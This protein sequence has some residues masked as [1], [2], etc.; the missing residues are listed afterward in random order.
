MGL[1][2]RMIPV[3]TNFNFVKYKGVAFVF[4]L[5]I[6]IM[7]LVSLFTHGVKLGI[8][9]SGG[10]VME[11]RAAH[12]ITVETFRETLSKY[13][14]DGAE[15]QEFGKEHDVIIRLQPKDAENQVA[16]VKKI[17]EA[18]TQELGEGIE[19]RKVDYVGPKVGKELVANGLKALIVAIIGMLI[20]IWVRF[21]W[22][23]G[24]GAVLSL[25]HD[26]IITLGFFVVTG[27]DFDHTSIAA[28]LT[29][30]GYSINDTVVIYDRIRENLRKHKDKPLKEL[31]NLSINETLSRTVMTVLT[32]LLVCLALVLVG[33]EVLRGFS[34]ALFFGIAFGTYSSIYVAAPILLHTGLKVGKQQ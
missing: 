26:A 9:F 20:Y 28:I 5:A 3:K 12:D 34:M 8:D 4:S 21:D 24:I 1:P 16:E 7:V 13:G 33:G 18:I 11:V 17:Q 27:F 22:Q 25:A 19:F 14:Y 6:S 29:I 31:I 23:F 32:T 10:I 2:I 15:I 30:I